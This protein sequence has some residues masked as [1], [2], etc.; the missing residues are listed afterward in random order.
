MIR[1]IY[2]V[3]ECTGRI[4]LR[5]P[6]LRDD[7]TEKAEPL[8]DA[9]AALQG[10]EEVRIRTFTGSVLCQFDPWKLQTDA[11]FSTIRSQLGEM[12]TIR[13][14]EH[15]EYE[16]EAL[17]RHAVER[18]SGVAR[19]LAGAV[20][21]MN[22]EVLRATGGTLD[23]GTLAAAGFLVTGMVEIVRNKKLTMPPWFNLGWWAFRTFSTVEKTAIA[24]AEPVDLSEGRQAQGEAE[25]AHGPH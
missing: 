24:M 6:V 3:H 12:P 5:I 25:G 9:L 17:V 7:D 14:G 21:G 20:K 22:L 19:S 8:A 15:P 13:S 23:L 1:A 11:I 16:N 10:M 2:L 18:G 4:R